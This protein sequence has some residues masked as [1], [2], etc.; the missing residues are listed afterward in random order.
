MLEER[1]RRHVHALKERAVET[2]GAEHKLRHFDSWC[3]KHELR[4]A[5]ASSSGA[6]P[7]LGQGL[8]LETLVACA[9]L[10]KLLFPPCPCPYTTTHLSHGNAE[11]LVL[12]EHGSN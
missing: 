1:R 12:H 10:S 8:Q 6:S 7:L 2:A 3:Q 5:S 4:H 9:M 11:R